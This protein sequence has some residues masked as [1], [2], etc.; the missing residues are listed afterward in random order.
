M[1]TTPK[2]ILSRSGPARRAN[3]VTLLRSPWAPVTLMAGLALL[4]MASIGQAAVTAY[5]PFNYAAGTLASGTAATG[6]GLTGNW[7]CGAAGT[8]GTGLTYTGLPVANNALSSA[9]GRQF[10]SL[11]SPLSSGTKWISFL[12]YASGNMGGNIDG[13]FFPNGNSTCLWFGFGLSPYS[14]TQGQ[15]GLGSMTTAGT[16]VQG[17]TSLQ[18]VGLANYATTHLIVLKIDFNTS[19]A[20]DTVTVYTNPVANASAPGVAAAGTCSSYDVGTISGVGLNVQGGANVMVDEIRVGDA[21][22]DVV[23]Y[24]GTPP[25]A[26]TGL[27]ATP[28]ANL[29]SLSWTAATGSPTSY[30]V[31][32]STTSGSGYTTI[33]TTTAPTVT[34]NDSVLGGQTYYYVVTAVNGGGE[35]GIS[36]ETSASPTLAAPAAPGGL[37]AT[38]GDAQVAL[39]WTA[40]SFATSYNVKRATASAGPYS[41]IG[42]TTAPTVTYTDS[43]GLNNGTTYYYVVSATGTGGTSSDTSPVSATPATPIPVYEPFNY[44]AGI[45]ANGTAATGSGLTGNWTCGAAGNIGTGLTYTGLP[46]ANNAL[47]SASGR[48]F[49]SL[50]TPLS[51]GTKW[52]SFLFSASGNMGGNIDGVF[53]PNGNSTCLWF[54]F[55]LSPYSPTQGQLGLGSM[56]TAGT[57]AQGATSLQQVGL[58]SYASTYLIVL[59]IDFNTSGAND[60]VTVY[61]NPVANASTPGVAA[62]G[63]CS[64]YDVGT[65]SGVGLNVQGGANVMVD[66]IRVG[67]T[68][69][70][71]VGFVSIPPNAPT[72]LNATPGANLVSL[73]WTAATGS[74]NGYNVKRSTVSGGPYTTVG[75]TTAPTVTYNDSVL[76]G[77]TYYYVVTAFNGGGEG[78]ISSGTS[79]SP[80]LA[81][82][83]APGGLRATAGD[84]QVALSWTA[85][86]FATSYHVKRATASA[87]PYTAIGTTTAPTVTYA[88]SSGL[89]NGTTYYY[90]VSATGTGGT[91]SDTSPVSATPNGPRPLVVDIARG[92]GIRWFASNGVT[93]Q[94]Q[95]S[96][97]L[98][99]TNTVWNNLGSS[100]PGN[101]AT[102]TVFDPVGQPHNFYQVLSI[103]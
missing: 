56:T 93:Y 33:G 50:T 46:V 44:A 100:V 16:A 91:S 31:K 68:Y 97:A 3:S 52:I 35:S 34:Y 60:T 71:V 79:A 74:P 98:L 96:S 22:G 86:S 24:I 102:N 1:H 59:N 23:G 61:T 32:R 43:S 58:G 21:Y 36:P 51:S 78:G 47:S 53:F 39:S 12:F 8:I 26:P 6:N 103:Q 38:A 49:V 90:V 19:G 75:S 92:A 4:A 95:W 64:S 83:A 10:V 7:T 87:G 42:T 84:A 80:T 62:A 55:G 2:T 99:G 27:N 54:G 9:S 28:G 82:A 30:N 13:V 37:A 29:V 73:S 81:A 41:P 89:N 88:D 94:I 17:A 101:G 14:P 20:N 72:G 45:L 70:D 69:G 63:T 48:Q 65:I 25:D 40:S 5:E 77:Q 67:N 18:Q 85:S 57:A 11:S 66:E 15:L 76:G